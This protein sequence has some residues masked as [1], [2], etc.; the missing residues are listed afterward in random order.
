M[1]RLSRAV[2][3][4]LSE[5]ALLGGLLFLGVVLIVVLMMAAL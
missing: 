1:K 5:P 2:A 3:T 4:A